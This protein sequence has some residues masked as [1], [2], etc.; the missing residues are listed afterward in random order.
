MTQDLLEE[1]GWDVFGHLSYSPNVAPSD[2]YLFQQLKQ[3][4]NRRHFENEDDLKKKLIEQQ[5]M[6]K[7]YRS[8][9][10]K[11]LIRKNLYHGTKSVLKL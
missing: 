3:H 6:A 10:V 7:Q 1:F 9:L 11:M 8:S 5:F 4:L 2:F